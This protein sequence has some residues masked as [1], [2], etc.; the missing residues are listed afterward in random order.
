MRHLATVGVE[1]G[2]TG[3]AGLGGLL[4]ILSDPA[5]R[6]ALAITPATRALVINTEGA[7]DPTNYARIM[8]A[9]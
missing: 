9:T 1:A 8:S 5:I 3:A 6:N 4:A 2:E 7:T